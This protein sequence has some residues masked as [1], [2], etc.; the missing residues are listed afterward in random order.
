MF[1]QSE[2][3]R[4]PVLD[5]LPQRA[6]RRE[7]C[8]CPVRRRPC[9]ASTAAASR[10]DRRAPWTTSVGTRDRVE[11]GQPARRGRPSGR[12]EREREAEDADGA[13]RAGGAAGDA[14]A[15]GAAADDQ[16]QPVQRA[17]AQ[18]FD[19]GDP[20][21]VELRRRR[22]RASPRDAIGLLDERDGDAGGVRGRRRGDEVRRR[23]PL[24]R[25]R[26]RARARRAARRPDAGG[27][28][29]CP[30]GVSSSSMCGYSA[31]CSRA[32]GGYVLR[33]LLMLCGGL[34]AAG[35]I[36]GSAVAA[37]SAP[38]P[39]RSLTPAATQRLWSELVQR[40]HVALAGDRRLPAAPSRL[41][42]PTDWLRLDDEAGRDGL[43]VRAVLHL[44]PTACRRQVAAAGGR[45]V[46]DPRAR[47]GLPRS[48]RDQRHRLDGVGRVDRAAPG[49]RP[50]S[51]RGGAWRP[52]ATTSPPA[53][54]GR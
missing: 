27:R 40:P 32:R 7:G 33:R 48:R 43:A 37:D 21:R 16:R 2:Q 4:K 35:A 45:G 25:R 53:T 8:D 47:A 29:P 51:R 28:S 1:A 13:G 18:L 11:L 38:K 46:A 44:D 14:R 49:T 15:R 22:R 17:G 39:V 24:P 6:Q 54:P 42:R 9:A 52:P 31:H 3:T 19:D 30:C 41:L 34:A 10:T 36:A 23:R 12:P 5:R 20:R 50:A 26:A